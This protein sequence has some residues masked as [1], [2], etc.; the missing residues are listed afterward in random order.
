[1]GS[2]GSG[3]LLRLELL[4]GLLVRPSDDVDMTP[5][6]TVSVKP[7]ADGGYLFGEEVGSTVQIHTEKP[8]PAKLPHVAVM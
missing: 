2:A 4:P 8:I 6:S 7:E 1:M 3:Q 5:E